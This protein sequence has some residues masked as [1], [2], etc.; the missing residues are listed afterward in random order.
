[1]KQ[2]LAKLRARVSAPPDGKGNAVEIVMLLGNFPLPDGAD[3][4][5]RMAGYVEAL[6]GFPL[7][8]VSEA[9]RRI[10]MG[11]TEVVRFSPTPVEL[12]NVVKA[13][14]RPMLDDIA[15]LRHLLDA[16]EEYAKLA[17][18]ALKTFEERSAFADKL[19]AEAKAAMDIDNA[20]LKAEA[21]AKHL[22]QVDIGNDLVFRE[23]CR[24]AGMPEN[25][26]ISPQL[27]DNLERWKN[28]ELS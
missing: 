6:A 4:K 27:R 13:V 26:P 28:G 14:L 11:E 2:A 7:W 19:V 1:M 18:P 22:A 21:K 16:S 12:G 10:R 15:D 24:I 17:S 9:C 5:L 8:A 20:E 3:A 25:S 23:S